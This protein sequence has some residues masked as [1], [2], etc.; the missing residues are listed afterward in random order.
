MLFAVFLTI[1]PKRAATCAEVTVSNCAVKMNSPK[2]ARP[3][4]VPATRFSN[5]K[6]VPHVTRVWIPSRIE[7]S[8]IITGLG[9]SYSPEFFI[10][11][12]ISTICKVLQTYL[13]TTRFSEPHMSW[14]THDSF[15]IIIR[16]FQSCH[17]KLTRIYRRFKRGHPG[18]TQSYL[19]YRPLQR[20]FSGG[21]LQFVHTHTHIYT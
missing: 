1:T 9:S 12:R 20:A 7:V 4:D 2:M 15:I 5:T 6:P 13:K 21:Q 11:P 3:A 10:F 17:P 18:L 14:V 8:S 19:Q 16:E